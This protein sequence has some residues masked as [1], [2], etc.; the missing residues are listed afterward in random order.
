MHVCIL[1]IFVA[2]F[3][4]I[5]LGV[6]PLVPNGKPRLNVPPLLE[7]S[8]IFLPKSDKF[9]HRVITAI[10][11]TGESEWRNF[12]NLGWLC[13]S[14]FGMHINCCYFCVRVRPKN[15]LSLSLAF[16]LLFHCSS[17][18]IRPGEAEKN[19]K[20]SSLYGLRQSTIA[21][22]MRASKT[23]CGRELSLG[24]WGWSLYF[25]SRAYTWKVKTCSFSSEA[26]LVPRAT[27]FNW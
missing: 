20:A 8:F 12:V 18:K 1:E 15:F 9:S 21:E 16:F 14:N 4:R 25:P 22:K 19:E 3:N 7:R 5:A 6:N 10:S 11:K 17:I 2:H 24:G 27:R 23:E 26:I 13:Q